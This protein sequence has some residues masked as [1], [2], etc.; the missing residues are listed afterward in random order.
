MLTAVN[1]IVDPEMSAQAN[2]LHVFTDVNLTSSLCLRDVSFLT[3]RT[4]RH[5]A[6]PA[7]GLGAMPG[8]HL[9]RLQNR[10]KGW[11]GLNRPAPSTSGEV[12]F[13][14]SQ[15]LTLSRHINSTCGN[16]LACVLQATW[17]DLYV[18]PCLCGDLFLNFR[19][20][21]M[22][23]YEAIICDYMLINAI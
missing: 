18:K 20:K 16:P 5:S 6:H 2:N 12:D 9:W 19:T 13:A 15:S 22:K 4:Q 7:P 10:W 17:E 1:T 21:D 3:E 11:K 23:E 14:N 8:P